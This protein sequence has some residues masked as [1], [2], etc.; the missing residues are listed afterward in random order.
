M[1]AL[2]N[3]LFFIAS[4]F[5]ADWAIPKF[6]GSEGLIGA[7]FTAYPWLWF[8]VYTVVVSHLTIT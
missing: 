4:Y 2:R 3:I 1:I 7:W 6:V 5:A 8:V